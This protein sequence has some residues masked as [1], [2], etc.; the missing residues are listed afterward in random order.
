MMKRLKLGKSDVTVA[1]ICLGCGSFGGTVKEAA[2][3]EQLDHYIELGGFFLDTAVVYCDWYEGERS[4]SQNY[5]GR[6]MESRGCRKDLTLSVKGCN[7][8]ITKITNSLDTAEHSG[9]RVGRKFIAEDI[10]L[11]MKNLRTDYLDI[12]TLHKDDP[13]V[14]IGEI[15]E[16]L[17]EQKNK[18]YIHAYGCS[19]WTTKRQAEAFE[20]AKAHDLDGFS[21][22]Q[23]RW[24][25]NVYA[26]GAH[27]NHPGVMDREAYDFHKKSG[28]AVM[29]Y[30]AAGR[31]YFQRMSQGLEIRKADHVEYDCPE[32][33]AIYAVLK[34]ISAETGYDMG[35]LTIAYI[36]MDHGFQA[37]PLFSVKTLEEMDMCFK[38]LDCKIPEKY[39][40]KLRQLRGLD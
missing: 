2:A 21:V 10:E 3:V 19:N 27:N 38:A 22:D 11:S 36:M 29:A 14:E 32:N 13:N 12:F 20:Y 39:Q 7:P 34:E 25:L 37:I 23:T 35:T 40:E 26:P 17:Q 30:G 16:A 15:L 28:V 4:A 6:W 31:G 1:P 33:E 18:G 8:T 9:P 5:L 24:C